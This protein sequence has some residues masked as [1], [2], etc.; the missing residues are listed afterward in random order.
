MPIFR[1]KIHT[2]EGG[3]L[4]TRIGDFTFVKMLKT[5]DAIEAFSVGMYQNSVGNQAVAKQWVGNPYLWNESYYWLSNEIQAYKFL[6]TLYKEKGALIQKHFPNIR[7]PK[8]L[9]IIEE[10]GRLLLLMEMIP[11]KPFDQFSVN[12]YI[13]EFEKVISYFRFINRI[14]IFKD[15]GI[16][17]RGRWYFLAVFPLI[18]L[19]AIAKHPKYAWDIIRGSLKFLSL[20]F[21]IPLKKEF[22]HR[23][24]NDSNLIKDGDTIG[25]IDFELSIRS[26]P[27][28]DLVS[29]AFVSW[30]V[31]GFVDAFYKS[32]IVQ[33]VCAS[34]EDLKAYQALTLYSAIH[35]FS[36]TFNMPVQY[37][38]SYLLHGISLKKREHNL[39]APTAPD[40]KFTVTVGIPA[41]N[42]EHNIQNIL[43]SVFSQKQT[44]YVIEKVI[45]ICDGCTDRTAL[46]A[47]QFAESHPLVEVHDDQKRTGKATRLNQIFQN[48]QS[49]ILVICDADT[50][51]GSPDTVENMVR[52]FH[53]KAVGI[54]GGNDTPMTPKTFFEKISV[55]H[56]RLWYEVRHNFRGGESP[57]NLHG[58]LFALRGELAKDIEIPK[59]VFADDTYLYFR[60]IELGFIFYF[61]KDAITK[62]RT[63]DNLREYISQSLRHLGTRTRITEEF[64]P[65]I[66]RY[67]FIPHMHKIKAFLRGVRKDPI[68]SLMAVVVDMGLKLIKSPRSKG[69]VPYWQQVHSTK[70]I[71]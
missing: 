43:S 7:I 23:D 20:V 42:E 14:A 67:R 12:E 58:V 39:A 6:H 52:P 15:T 9:Q 68:F 28:F 69:V 59:S 2:L 37:K 25:I 35:L 41:Y 38:H 65:W 34:D 46:E 50:V 55:A 18:F 5:R 71:T 47:R 19:R 60:A 29:I 10:K 70:K 3:E 45:V 40:H 44:S 30:H 1:K 32:P 53:D 62:Y 33:E 66:N 64:G 36:G 22:V 54:V 63:P 27:L 31:P 21:S 24:L 61:A 51:F 56:A 13:E 4:P 26:H 48:N 57:H 49:E 17:S 16:H 11:G 8:V